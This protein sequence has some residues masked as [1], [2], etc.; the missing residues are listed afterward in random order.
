MG[1]AL[2]SSWAQMPMVSRIIVTGVLLCVISLTTPMWAYIKDSPFTP[3]GE[4][5]CF[6]LFHYCTGKVCTSIHDNLVAGREVP[7]KYIKTEL[8]L[9]SFN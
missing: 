5:L 7:C 9:L 2:D 1:S 4:D 8:F 3:P 6:G